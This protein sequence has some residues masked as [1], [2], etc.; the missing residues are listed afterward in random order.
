LFTWELEFKRKRERCGE[1][2]GEREEEGTRGQNHRNREIG[3]TKIKT[4]II[5]HS[6][7]ITWEC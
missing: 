4:E 2:K 5:T 7:V 1:R 6:T 3:N